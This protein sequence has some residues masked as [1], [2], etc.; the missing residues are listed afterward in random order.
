M[1]A[2]KKLLGCLFASVI[3]MGSAFGSVDKKLISSAETYLNS[4]TGLAGNFT[5]FSNGKKDLG[6]FSM[7]RPGK[8]RLDYKDMP[9][10]LISDGKDLYFF[11]KS[12][13]Q[14]TTVPLTST[15]AGILVRKNINLQTAD[16]VVTE[17]N[18][19]K[20]TF[21]LKMHMKDNEGVGYMVVLFDNAPVKLNSW[22]VVDAMGNQTDVT[23]NGLKVKTDFEKNYFQIQR[24]KTVSTAGGD[25]F[26]D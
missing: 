20:D 18:Q 23:F 22:S 1:K 9:I 4:I 16:I 17:T 11:D 3:L 24:H 15:P 21:S 2:M 14:I 6:T 10:Q 19:G 26:Y 7:L 5:Q 12:L 13:D 8:V 25:S